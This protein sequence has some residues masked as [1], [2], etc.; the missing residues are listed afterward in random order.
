[1]RKGSL[2][3]VFLPLILLVISFGM[4]SCRVSKEANYRELL[5]LQGKLDTLPNYAYPVIPHPIQKGD[6]VSITVYSDNPEATAVYNQPISP[7]GRIGG[8][9]SGSSYPPGYQVNNRGSVYLHGLGEVE[10]AGK[11]TDLLATELSAAY[12]K[13]LSNPYVEVRLMNLS[14]TVLGEVQKPGV[15][16]ITNQRINVLQAIGAA[17]D[18]T[19]YGRKGNILVIREQNGVRSFGRIDLNRSDLFQSEFF[20]L[21]PNDVVYIEP[22]KRK[23]AL[24]DQ[25]T[26]RTIS[27]IAGITSILSA[28]ALIASALK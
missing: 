15:F 18:I 16:P 22:N 19:V 14:F 2:N 1:M 8:N 3:R 27:L 5:Y 28:L 6:L 9:T 4:H 17:G 23:T 24:S 26:V 11:T 25:Q 12:T 7:A 21:R 10:V 20:Y 13:Y